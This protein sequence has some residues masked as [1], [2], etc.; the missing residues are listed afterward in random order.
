MTIPRPAC[1]NGIHSQVGGGQGGTRIDGWGRAYD[2]PKDFR[3]G[4]TGFSAQAQRR[5][6]VENARELTLS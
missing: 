1:G 3:A 5:I 4:L 2:Q 6:M